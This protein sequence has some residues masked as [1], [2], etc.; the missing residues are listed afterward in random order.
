MRTL[1]S[2]FV[3]LNGVRAGWRLLIFIALTLP[4]VF[5]V[6]S[7]AKLTPMLKA[8]VKGS[9]QGGA[10]DPLGVI[11]L[12]I[13][14]LLPI[15]FA[16]WLM[17]KIEHRAF[18]SYGLAARCGF[19]KFYWRGIF[20]GLATEAFVIGLILAF[21]GF[22]FGTLPLDPAGMAKYDALWAAAFVLVGLQEEFLYRGYLLF[23]LST[24]I[25][26]WPAAI[27][28]SLIFG[29]VHSQTRE[30]TWPGLLK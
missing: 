9:M 23:T 7:V 21:G 8:A 10:T 24:G 12:Q 28:T 13:S 18:G 16:A 14:V 3:G 2:A 30:K 26:F 1:R 27:V 22:S 20:W 6:Q 15:L 19:G 4:L 25:R 17:S 29:A 11:V 5:L